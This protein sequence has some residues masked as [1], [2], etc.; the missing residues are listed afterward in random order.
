MADQQHH[1]C[2]NCQAQL[3]DTDRFC[4]QCGQ[5]N[6]N[7]RIS[8]WE[9]IKD[10]LTSNFNFDTKAGRTLVDLIFRPG[11][12]TQ[13]YLAG[14]RVSYVKPLQL[15]FFV[16]FLYFL[17]LNVSTDPKDSIQIVPDV[18]EAADSVPAL[19]TDR[20]EA[21]VSLDSLNMEF[22][23]LDEPWK[24][25]VL[26]KLSKLSD[27]EAEEAFVRTLFKNLSVAMFFLMPLFALILWLFNRKRS[28]YYL[29]AMVFSIHFHTLAFILFST[30]MI[31]GFAYDRA[32]TTLLFIQLALL[33]LLLSVRRVYGL[34]WLRAAGQTLGIS[35]LYTLVLGVAILITFLLSVISF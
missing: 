12:I 15:Y 13:E 22:G 27:P 16:S 17:L 6:R 34:G 7:L 8:F 33:F 3:R 4:P 28:P 32:F 18:E 24:R 1:P 2:L 5:E 30:D 21:T 35:V 10:F 20:T 25:E 14:R 19:I 9:F 31:I 23:E 26:E 11:R 29:N